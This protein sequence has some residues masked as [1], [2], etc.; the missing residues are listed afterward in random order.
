M[1]EYANADAASLGIH[2]VENKD[3]LETWMCEDLQAVVLFEGSVEFGIGV[4]GVCYRIRENRI[5]W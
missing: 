3:G 1:L 2:A 4:G 5:L